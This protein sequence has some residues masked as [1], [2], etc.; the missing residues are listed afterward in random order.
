MH[1]KNCFITLTYNPENLPEDNSVNVEHW[2]KFAKKLRKAKGPFRFLHCGE[3][4]DEEKRPHYHAC[5]FG[6]DFSEDRVLYEDKENH[7]LW[8]SPQLETIWGMGFCPIGPLNYDTAAYC[9]A[10]TQKKITGPTIRSGDKSPER[11]AYETMSTERKEQQYQR[12]DSDTGEIT[13]VKPE[14]G[15]MSRNKGLGQTWFDKY[16]KDVY[17][18][19]FV[20]IKGKKFRPPKYYD[21]LLEQQNPELLKKLKVIRKNVSNNQKQ[22]ETYERRKIR[23]T[24]IKAQLA[25]KQRKL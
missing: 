12:V 3:Y 18:D 25:T 5:I 7:T 1:Q 6:H 14:Y 13:T 16:W 22:D 21:Q 4:G 24:V 11:Q 23:N 20:V 8:T 9:A 19:D 15:T 17:P 10:Y 2:Q